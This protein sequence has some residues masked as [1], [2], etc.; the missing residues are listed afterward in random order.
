MDYRKFGNTYYIRVDKNEEIIASVIEVCKKENVRCCMFNGIGGCKSAEIQ[1]FDP[2]KREFG[3]E[4]VNGMLEL[5]SI[6]GDVTTDTDGSL[7]HHTH[8]MFSYVEDDEHKTIGGHLK[9][10]TVLYTAEI[11]M[12][13]VV[14]GS[15]GRKKDEETGTGFW[16]FG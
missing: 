7:Y 4:T 3:T 9:S 14:G 11:E 1:T 5:V 8:A 15:I 6:M 2:E 13:P 16:D 12:R 10:T